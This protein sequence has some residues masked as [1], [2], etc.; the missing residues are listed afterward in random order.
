MTKL[1]P[2]LYYTHLHVE[3]LID[4]LDKK[5]AA[6]VEK[7]ASEEQVEVWRAHRE[8]VWSLWREIV[9]EKGWQGMHQLYL[10]CKALEWLC[11]KTRVMT[12]AEASE[13]LKSER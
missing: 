2:P 10:D 12:L 3:Y 8:N 6:L 5:I 9:K 4:G 13:L 11:P 1:A 7:G